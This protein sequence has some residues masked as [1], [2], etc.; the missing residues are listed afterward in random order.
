MNTARIKSAADEIERNKRA[1]SWL[2]DYGHNLTGHD[3]AATVVVKPAFAASCLGASDA[4]EI[5]SVF[6]RLRLPEIVQDAIKNCENTIEISANAI[7]D[8][9]AVERAS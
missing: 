8:E 2:R 4:G 6:A 3:D 9:L 7:R 1:L 5:L